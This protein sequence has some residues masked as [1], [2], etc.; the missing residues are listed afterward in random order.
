MLMIFEKILAKLKVYGVITDSNDEFNINTLI[1]DTK[2]EI[3]TYCNLKKYPEDNL[4]LDNILV[5]LVVLCFL[6]SKNMTFFN[7]QNSEESSSNIASN[8]IKSISVGDFSVSYDN[9][10]SSSNKSATT[11]QNLDV[12]IKKYYLMLN[13]FRRILW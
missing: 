1:N 7:S 9:G 8:E 3:T 4:Q 2:I 12:E 6:K 11:A 10:S 13:K 5:N